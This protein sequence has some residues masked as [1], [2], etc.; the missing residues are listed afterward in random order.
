MLSLLYHCQD[1]YRTWLYIR[2][3]RWV[4]YKKRERLTLPEE[5]CSPPF[6]GVRVAHLFSFFCVVLFCVLTFHVLGSML[7]VTISFRI[8]TMFGSS[9]LLV[10]CSHV[11]FTLFVF[12]C[13]YNVN[14][15]C[16][17]FGFVFFLLSIFDCPF[18]IL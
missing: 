11:L 7:S 8:K 15:T 13:A 10:V 1:L 18:G 16:C 14:K 17:V 5:L 6:C 4:S 3:R 2:V 9:L 12:F